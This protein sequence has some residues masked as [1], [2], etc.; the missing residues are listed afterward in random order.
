M[1]TSSS[2]LSIAAS[3]TLQVVRAAGGGGSQVGSILTDGFESADMSSPGYPDFTWDA[4][5]ATSIVTMNPGPI[6]VWNNVAVN[7]AGSTGT[8]W[9][10]KDGNYSLRF[11]YTPTNPW[12]EQK[13]S[14]TNS[15]TDIWLTFWLRVP[16]NY[17]HAE[18]SPDNNKL[19][20]LYMDG[21]ET[22]GTGATVVWELWPLAG[23]GSQVALRSRYELN[24]G[25][26]TG[27]QQFTPFISV[28]TDRGRW[29]EITLHIKASSTQ[30][31]TDGVQE[32]WRRWDGEATKTLFHSITNA[33]LPIP[34]S[35]TAWKAGYF[36][37]Y[38]NAAYAEN[39]EWLIDS[40][41][42]ST[43]SLL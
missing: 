20:A 19:F 21:Y 22:A 42:I 17:V 16:V 10:A 24:G 36:L 1:A 2:P 14:M 43:E 4:N 29:M 23:G 38:H 28:P 39:T 5:N 8:N 15:Y 13:F 31:A 27:H 6:A 33:V 25:N 37:G 7:N 30:T 32:M 12:A 26:N 40:I 18:A 34:A 3:R 11:R 41:A 35:G 9:T